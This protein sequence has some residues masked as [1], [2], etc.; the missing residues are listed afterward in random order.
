LN[1]PY[2][3][4]KK[5]IIYYIFILTSLNGNILAGQPP[6][7]STK[8]EIIHSQLER[9]SSLHDS[10]FNSK[11]DFVNG[12]LYYSGGNS[13]VHPFF[14][15]NSWSPAIIPSSGK[16]NEINLAKYDLHL[17]YLVVL[18]NSESFSYPIYLNKEFTKEFTIYGHHFKYIEDFNRAAIDDLVPGYYEELY[19]GETKFLVRQVKLKKFDNGE[20]AEVYED[21]KYFFLKNGEKYFKILRQKSLIKALNDHKKEIKAFMK[22]NHLLYSSDNYEVAVKILAYYDTL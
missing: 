18:L 3:M 14:G 8:R 2:N 21:R 12:K 10:V 13:F 11:K 16:R 19:Q 4:A 6:D 1:Y 15:D 9:L 22:K 20:M 17:D 5:K 7:Y